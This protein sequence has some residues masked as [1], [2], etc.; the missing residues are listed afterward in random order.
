[1]DTICTPVSREVSRSLSQVSASTSSSS[2]LGTSPTSP[3]ISASSPSATGGSD[4]DSALDTHAP[5]KRFDKEQLSAL[6]L[7]F[8]SNSQPSAADIT[9]LAASIGDSQQRVKSWVR[10]AHCVSV[11]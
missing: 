5:K 9:A 1:M 10:P 2:S 11:C 6:H 4:S 7:S 8:E 3:F